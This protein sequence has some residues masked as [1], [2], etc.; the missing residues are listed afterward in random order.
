MEKK[1]ETKGQLERKIQNALVFVPKDKEYSWIYFT[2]KGLR[3]ET[4]SDSCV[5]STGFHKHVF[6]ELLQ[7]SQDSLAIHIQ[8]VL[9]GM[10]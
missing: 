9:A 6:Q 10:A 1:K 7:L 5:I 8:P 2:D 4:T 3:L